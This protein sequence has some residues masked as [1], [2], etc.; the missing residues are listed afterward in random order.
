M[1]S[2]FYRWNATSGSVT[3]AYAVAGS[4]Y[5]YERG[6]GGGVGRLGDYNDANLDA[7]NVFYG[8]AEQGY[9][10]TTWANTNWATNVIKTALT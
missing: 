10:T 7:S 6:F 2:M 9:A 3:Q 4:G 1:A 5:L 8:A